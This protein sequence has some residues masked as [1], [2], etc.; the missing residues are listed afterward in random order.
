M[1]TAYASLLMKREDSMIAANLERRQIGEQFRLLDA[2]SLPERPY[3]QL[4]APGRHGIRRRRRTR[5]RPAR[6]RVAR[7]SRLQLQ[8]REEEVLKAL[9]LPVLA[10]IPVMTSDSERRAAKRRDW[11]MDAGGTALLLAAGAV[12]VF[13]RLQL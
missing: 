2:A 11:A 7:V 3:N 4:A 8:R 12:V 5:A 1:Q 6:R 13:W 9:S 10:S